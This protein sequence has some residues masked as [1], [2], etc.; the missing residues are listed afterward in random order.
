MRHARLTGQGQRVSVSALDASISF[1]FYETTKFSYRGKLR[2]RDSH[3]IT[4]VAASTQPCKDGYVALTFA[5]ED[6]WQ[7]F[8]DVIEAPELAQGDFETAT[9]RLANTDELNR[10]RAGGAGEKTQDV[11]RARVPGAARRRLAGR[12]HRGHP[13]LRAAAGA[14]LVRRGAAG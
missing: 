8:C 6:D 4:G 5:G 3:M 9:L 14:R 7:R 1:D 13:A 11:R 2:R 12:D 10:L